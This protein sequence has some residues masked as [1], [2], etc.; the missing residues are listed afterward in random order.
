MPP[1]TTVPRMCYICR[2]HTHSSSH[3]AHTHVLS[4]P[5]LF[6][7]GSFCVIVSRHCFFLTGACLISQVLIFLTLVCVSSAAG[8]L[9]LEEGCFK[10]NIIAVIKTID[11]NHKCRTCLNI[12]SP[13][14]YRGTVQVWPC[15]DDQPPRTHKLL[16]I[17]GAEGWK[18]QFTDNLSWSSH[19]STLVK[20]STPQ[21]NF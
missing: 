4:P 7:F 17:K 19:L 5:L 21:E 1:T 14:L 10:L 3:A 8:D 6:P 13:H 2:L 9:R 20:K 11:N 16:C 12:S 15:Y 18:K